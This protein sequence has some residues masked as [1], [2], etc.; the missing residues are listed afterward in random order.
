MAIYIIAILALVALSTAFSGAEAAFL[1]VSDIRLR[2]LSD[3]KNKKATEVLQLKA[4]MRRLLVVLLAAQTI[5]DICSSALA[6]AVATKAT[7]EIGIGLAAGLMSLVILI[8][9]N[10]APKSLAAKNPEGWV[11]AM[12]RPVKAMMWLLNPLVILIDR[13]AGRFLPLDA[14]FADDSVSEEE[15]KTMAKMAAQAG[16]LETD[17]K[18]M[19]DRV[20]LFNDISAFDVMTPIEEVV[21]IDGGRSI[22]L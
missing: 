19:I 10:L 9:A 8:L 2:T 3:K 6:T 18:E 11:L 4:N 20:F 14:A 15:I 21:M 13:T 7:G 16:T 22:G 17:E 5:S 12:V 1:S